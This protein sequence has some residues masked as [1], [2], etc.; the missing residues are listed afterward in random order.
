M[1]Q[2]VLSCPLYMTSGRTAEKT[3]PRVLL[4]AY[5]PRVSVCISPPIIAGQWLGKHIPAAMNTHATIEELLY[6]LSSMW[7]IADQREVGD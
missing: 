6:M 4:L 5:F 1:R 2:L 7:S 3:P